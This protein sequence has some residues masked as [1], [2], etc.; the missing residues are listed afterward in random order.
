[1]KNLALGNRFGAAIPCNSKNCGSC[2]MISTEQ[3]F[4]TND[5]RIKCAEGSCASYNVIYLVRCSLCNKCY[6]GRTARTLRTRIGEHRQYFYKIIKGENFDVDNDDYALGYHLHEHGYADRND[7]N[8]IFNVSILEICSPKVLE[9]KE[10]RY[11]HKLKTL[12]P[13]GLNLSNPFGI[14]LLH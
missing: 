2:N 10:H 13:G 8:K 7:F 14:P 1:M 3:H 9:V 11:I 6:V 12:A 4:N 5:M